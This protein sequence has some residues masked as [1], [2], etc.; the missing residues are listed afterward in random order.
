VTVHIYIT[1]ERAFS[2]YRVDPANWMPSTSAEFREA[3]GS[4]APTGR[5]PAWF[6]TSKGQVEGFSF[7]AKESFIF[8]S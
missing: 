2:D 8:L 3:E 5:C 7:Q 6:F 1:P 4:S